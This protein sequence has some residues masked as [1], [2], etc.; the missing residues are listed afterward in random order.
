MI[1]RQKADLDYHDQNDTKNEDEEHDSPDS[2]IARPD[3]IA[4]DP[5]ATTPLATAP[6]PLSIDPAPSDNLSSFAIHRRQREKLQRRANREA[7]RIRMELSF[8]RDAAD[9]GSG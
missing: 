3:T 1:K 4:L 5:M 2:E 9:I 6:V 8:A 7:D